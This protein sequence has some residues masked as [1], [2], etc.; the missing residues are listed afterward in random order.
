MLQTK[1]HPIKTIMNLN[2]LLR[3]AM[4][5]E[6]EEFKLSSIQS[7]ILGFLWYK[8]NHHEKAFQKELEAE[9]K[10]RRSSVCSVVQCLEK[11]GLLE[12]RSVSTDARQK[13]L[14]LTDEGMKIQSEVINRLEQM[15]SKMNGWLTPEERSCWIRCVNKIET[16]L[17]E[18]EYD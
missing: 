2:C 3:R 18:A 12:R 8:R 15:E 4:E 17:K 11:R 16:G 5:Q 7:R 1:D 10:I 13:E 6:M 9:F 14:V